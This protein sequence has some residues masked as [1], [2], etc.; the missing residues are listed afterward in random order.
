MGLNT[1]NFVA[2]FTVCGF[3]IG[4]VFVA[5]NISE[6]VEI[7]L[8]SF[9]I[10]FFFYIVIHIAIMN[11]IEPSTIT[12]S[13]FNKEKYEEVNEYLVSELSGREKK[14]DSMIGVR[15]IGS[16]KNERNKEKAA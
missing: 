11:Y 5:L 10:T 14:M 9:M 4:L 6:P 1:E 3:F 7:I 2:F 8:Y 16:A 15:E 13:N 12:E